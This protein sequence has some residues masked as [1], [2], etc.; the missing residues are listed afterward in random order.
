MCDEDVGRKGITPASFEENGTVHFAILVQ[1]FSEEVPIHRHPHLAL[2][3]K[4]VSSL[5]QPCETHLDEFR[6]EGLQG[7]EGLKIQIA[8]TRR[9]V[10]TMLPGIVPLQGP[11]G[12]S[13][14]SKQH[15]QDDHGNERLSDA[16]GPKEL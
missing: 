9:T 7:F 6:G 1:I 5:C 2:L 12:G 3:P 13:P 8:T 10:R 11:K 14:E 4:L 16:C 15:S